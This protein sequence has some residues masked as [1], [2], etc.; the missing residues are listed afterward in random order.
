LYQQHDIVS[1]NLKNAIKKF[2]KL[3]KD[4]NLRLII[5]LDDILET[6]MFK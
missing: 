4:E 3:Y 6:G 5:D 2:S 1:Y